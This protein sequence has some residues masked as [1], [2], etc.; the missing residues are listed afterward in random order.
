MTLTSPL[1]SQD[2]K[3]VP[4]TSVLPSCRSH[5]HIVTE[6]CEI[7]VMWLINVFRLLLCFSDIV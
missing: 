4:K 5:R 3:D 6:V 1:Q 7:Y 2:K